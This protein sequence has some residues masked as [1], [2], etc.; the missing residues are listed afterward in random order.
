MQNVAIKQGL[1]YYKK[2][3]VSHFVR[4]YVDIKK[5]YATDIRSDNLQ[6]I[7]HVC[8][9]NFDL[10]PSWVYDMER[11]IMLRHKLK[12]EGCDNIT[13]YKTKTG[14]PTKRSLIQCINIAKNE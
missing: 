13:S 9:G 4:R 2:E 10:D 7:F 11:E 1:K 3:R 6:K 8:Y 5:S 14:R 12:Y